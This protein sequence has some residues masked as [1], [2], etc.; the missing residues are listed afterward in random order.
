MAKSNFIVRGGADFSGIKKEMQK[1]Q[2]E[3]S[4]FQSSVNKTMSGVG[5]A[6]K[7]GLGVI[8]VRAISDF[9][10]STIKAGS[11][12]AEIQNVVNV[13]FGAMTKDIEEFSKTAMTNFGLGE[14]SARSMHPLWVLCSSLV[15]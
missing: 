10:K 4:N 9:V 15:V 8:S 7:I 11:D 6:I 1:T 5:K 13:T 14:L 3:M 2:K 12:V